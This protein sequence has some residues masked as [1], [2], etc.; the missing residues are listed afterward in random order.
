[1]NTQTNQSIDQSNDKPI[2]FKIL[3]RTLIAFGILA[4]ILF[5]AFYIYTLNYYRADKSVNQVIQ[6]LGS[7][8]EKKDN[9]T[10]FYPDKANDKHIAFVFYP[11]GKVEAKAYAP[12][13]A[14]LSDQG[15]T[16]I[17]V[18]MPFNLAVFHVNAGN[19]IYGDLKDIKEWYIGGHS[20]GGV[21][22]SS[23]ADKNPDHWKGL[24]LL[25]SYPANKK[26]SVKHIA[27]YGSN[28]KVL[29][30]S[31]LSGLNTVKIEGGIHGYFGNYGKQ[32]GDGTASITRDEQQ[33]QTVDAILDF[34]N[35]QTDNQGNK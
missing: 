11:G 30:Q 16:S 22:A 15:I 13:L 7:K 31:K 28:D 4:L 35:K 10:I 14:K 3:K 19:K 18:K 33:S 20:L 25:A 27:I 9:Q 2:W 23:C 17:L 1:M 6:Q 34:M 5:V 21:M 26:T 32:K 24:I 8:V 12:L 29:D